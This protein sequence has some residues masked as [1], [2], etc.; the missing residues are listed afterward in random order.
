MAL[1]DRM[2]TSKGMGRQGSEQELLTKRAC[3]ESCY[4][5]TRAAPKDMGAL[6]RDWIARI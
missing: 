5:L 4:A 1:K 2:C 3:A 6:E